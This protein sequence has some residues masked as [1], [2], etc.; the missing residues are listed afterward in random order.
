[1][2]A[3]RTPTRRGLKGL[4]GLGKPGKPTARGNAAAFKAGAK[5]F[6]A[7]KGAT[8]DLRRVVRLALE[9]DAPLK[10]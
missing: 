9:N 4:L 8:A 7:S 1:M 3:H 10:R 5:S 2:V 6:R